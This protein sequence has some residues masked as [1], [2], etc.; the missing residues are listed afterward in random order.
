MKHDVTVLIPV[1]QRPD[2]AKK[3]ADSIRQTSDCHIMFLCS[4][5]DQEEIEACKATGERVE[6]MPCLNSKGDY[7]KK[8]NYGIEVSD[9]DWVL[10]AADDLKFYLGWYDYAVP[11]IQQGFQVIGTNDL[12]SPRVTN[13]SHSTHSFINK[14]YVE[15]F[16]LIDGT[17]GKALFEGYWHEYVDDE[18]VG[19]AKARN[20]WAF[21]FESRIEHLHYMYGLAEADT[22]Y[23]MQQM[24]MR[25][26]LDLFL[27]RQKLWT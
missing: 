3:V 26:S 12:H 6:I 11:Y 27:E 10:M 7:A 14:G 2:N 13:G 4:P 15:R 20:T 24:R 25:K 19:T 5:N 22:I 23:L 16:G 8:I 18:L 1:L 17:L 21:S 9:T